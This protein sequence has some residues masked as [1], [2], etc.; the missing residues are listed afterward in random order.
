MDYNDAINHPEYRKQNE[1]QC[2]YFDGIT[3][4]KKPSSLN[5]KYYQEWSDGYYVFLNRLSSQ[6]MEF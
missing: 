2:G 4:N 5:E 6:D 3:G 1:Y